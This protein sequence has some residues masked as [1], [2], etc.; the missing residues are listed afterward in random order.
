MGLG[1]A[2]RRLD[3]RAGVQKGPVPKGESRSTRLT[4]VLV[5]ATLLPVLLLLGL[6]AVV[7]LVLAVL[8]GRLF[9]LLTALWHG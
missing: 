4:S 3:D 8:A 6:H 7:A 9:W 1:S 5:G 2:L